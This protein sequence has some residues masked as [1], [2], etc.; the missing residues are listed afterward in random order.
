MIDRKDVG[1]RKFEERSKCNRLHLDKLLLQLWSAWIITE[2]ITFI[3]KIHGRLFVYERN[4]SIT[5]NFVEIYL[6]I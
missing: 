3:I 2:E 5:R 4:M 6:K 1:K